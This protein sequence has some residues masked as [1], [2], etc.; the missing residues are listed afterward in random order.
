MQRLSQRMA[1]LRKIAQLINRYWIA[2]KTSFDCVIPDKHE[3]NAELNSSSPSCVYRLANVPHARKAGDV[4]SFNNSTLSNLIQSTQSSF[5]TRCNVFQALRN[6]ET[7]GFNSTLISPVSGS[8][9]SIVSTCRVGRTCTDFA[10]SSRFENNNREYLSC[11]INTQNR[12]II[13]FCNDDVGA[14]LYSFISVRISRDP[15]LLQLT[16]TTTVEMVLSVDST[17]STVCLRKSNNAINL[18]SVKYR[19]VSRLAPIIRSACSTRNVGLRN[20]NCKTP[21]IFIACNK[22]GITSGKYFVQDDPNEL[23]INK[24]A[25]VAS[26]W[27]FVNSPAASDIP[28]AFEDPDPIFTSGARFP[29]PRSILLPIAARLALPFSLFIS[30]KFFLNTYGSIAPIAPIALIMS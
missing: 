6:A 25:C 9:L 17:T 7:L 4:D 13:W 28:F 10:G 30:S 3:T 11:C 23:N 8:S 18:G 20:S 14:F 21:P 1:S 19:C 26:G 24:I 16:S 2:C 5:V 29:S 15:K 12:S 27:I 22:A